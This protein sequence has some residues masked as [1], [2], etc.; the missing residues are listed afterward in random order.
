MTKPYHFGAGVFGGMLPLVATALLG[1]LFVCDTKDVD[2][3]SG[4]GIETA[5]AALDEIVFSTVAA[6]ASV[7]S[8]GRAI[9]RNI[10]S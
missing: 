10:S 3:A 5:A 7:G 6:A 2:V 4:S 9:E 8:E 1:A